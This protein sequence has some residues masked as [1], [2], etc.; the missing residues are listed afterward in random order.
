MKPI[1]LGQDARTIDSN[2]FLHIPNCV[3]TEEGV[4]EYLGSEIPECEEFGLDPNKAYKV[5]RPLSVLEACVNTFNNK[6]VLNEHIPVLS[7]LPNKESWYGVT[8]EQSY[9]RKVDGKPAQLCG[10]MV[11]YLKEAVDK[12][13][14]GELKSISCGY[15]RK[16][17]KESGT[18]NGKPYD[19]VIE[20]MEGNH[21]AFVSLPR[22][23]NAMIGDSKLKKELRSMKN[24]IA[25][26]LGLDNKPE[27]KELGK[28]HDLDILQKR[29]LELLENVENLD[30]AGLKELKETGAMIAAILSA[31]E[32]DTDSVKDDKNLISKD[33]ESPE[34]RKMHE[35]AGFRE[36]NRKHGEN[37]PETDDQRSFDRGTG[38]R[39]FYGSDDFKEF[40][41]K[42]IEALLPKLQEQLIKKSDESKEALEDAA[43]IMG[44]VDKACMGKD[45][46]SVYTNIL[47]A[48]GMDSKTFTTTA[49]KRAAVKTMIQTKQQKQMSQR[50]PVIAMDSSSPLIN[51]DTFKMMANIKGV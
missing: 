9:I 49:E 14:G 19:L 48:V 18:W 37:K 50:R 38:F 25:R 10:N 11:I 28:D 4:E 51:D 30:E 35:G 13:N 36:Y 1:A 47:K 22:I 41:E 33:D 29:H 8:G 24:K 27:T 17:R 5:Y 31:V 12:I 16:H 21:V 45:A 15:F 26:M 42:L 46:D 23:A 6:P 32:G 40:T 34:I 7:E 20:S 43:M 2:G 3:F 44:D 39:E